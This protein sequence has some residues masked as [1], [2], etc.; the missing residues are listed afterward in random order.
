MPE[1]P[2]CREQLVVL[3]LTWFPTVPGNITP[4]GTCS[5][6]PH[7]GYRENLCSH[8]KECITTSVWWSGGPL[9][10][11]GTWL[12]LVL[13]NKV[14][15]GRPAVLQQMTNG[16]RRWWRWTNLMSHY[17]SCSV[18]ALLPQAPLSASPYAQARLQVEDRLCPT[19]AA[20]HCFP[21]SSPW[22]PSPGKLAWKLVQLDVSL[23]PGGQR[24]PQGCW[25]SSEMRAGLLYA[26][27]EH[28]RGFGASP[29]PAMPLWCLNSKN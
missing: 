9:Q 22:I 10:L 29:G 17:P 8:T 28:P 26:S 12:P 23:P 24:P 14:P 4:A 21:C 5:H 16:P 2:G 3:L 1:S 7:A 15:P 20:T 25:L 11:S 13:T 27:P 19:A 6:L 18:L